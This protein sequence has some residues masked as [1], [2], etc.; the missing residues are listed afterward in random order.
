MVPNLTQT[1]TYRHT[2][3]CF[4]YVIKEKNKFIIFLLYDTRE[5][6]EKRYCKSWFLYTDRMLSSLLLTR[7]VVYNY[8]IF[9][10]NSH[11]K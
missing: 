1:C 6:L 4:L 10:C 11:T 8:L 2:D 7:T 3:N 9:N 5:D